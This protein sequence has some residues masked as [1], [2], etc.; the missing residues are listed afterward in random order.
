M[1]PLLGAKWR[2]PQAIFDGFVGGL[3]R[4]FHPSRLP[5][6][7]PVRLGQQGSGLKT[8]I[9]GLAAAS[10]LLLAAPAFAAPDCSSDTFSGERSCIYGRKSIGLPG[11]GNQILTKDGQMTFTRLVSRIG[12]QPINVS[13]VLFRVDDRRTIQ[14]TAT[15]LSQPTVNCTGSLCTWSWTVGAALPGPV[16]AELASAKKLVIGFRGD[17][18]TI[19]EQELRRGGQI[20][21]KFQED[22]REH[23]PAVLDSSVG[24]ALLMEGSQLSPYISA[25]TP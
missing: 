15:N 5:Y 20:F 4:V 1:I 25:P 16:L 13:A 21:Q 9:L 12:R 11:I 14:I 22:I 3:G 2:R 19:E 7:E 23:E 6:T 10:G 8:I 24:E 18:Q 17:G